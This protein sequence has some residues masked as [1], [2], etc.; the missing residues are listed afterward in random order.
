M[1]FGWLKPI[2]KVAGGLLGI[3]GGQSFDYGK[4]A[5]AIGAGMGGA[6]QASATNR[7]EEYGGQMDLASILMQRDLARLGLEGQA[8]RDYNSQTIAREQEGRLGRDDAWK[9]LLSAQR[10]LSPNTRP[11]LSPYSTAPRQAT[12]MERQGASAMSDEVMARLQGG[13][14]IEAPT[15][16]DTSFQYDPMSTIDPRLLKAGGMEKASGW[17]SPILKY[18]GPQR[19]QQPSENPK[20]IGNVSGLSDKVYRH[21]RF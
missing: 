9:K 18:L 4:L 21:V 11:S 2:G 1:A 13:N 14:P 10:T 7:G 12:D 5:G 16:R 17:L 3:G 15:R 6:S 8:D 19:T 20:G